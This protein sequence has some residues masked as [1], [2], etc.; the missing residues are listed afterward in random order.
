MK[1]ITSAVALAALLTL[2]GCSGGFAAP[3]L[4]HSGNAE[5]STESTTESEAPETSADPT[6]PADTAPVPTSSSEAPP[7]PVAPMPPI[8]GSG[9]DVVP[10][11]AT[12]FNAIKFTNEG[13]S[14]FVVKTDDGQLLVNEIG[15]YTGTVVVNLRDNEHATMLAITSSGNWTVTVIPPAAIPLKSG[16][17]AGSG[18]DVF[19]YEQ[20]M[21]PVTLS[22]PTCTSN[23][24]LH[25]MSLSS[26]NIDLLV[27]EI[28]A[29]TGTV[30]YGGP[31]LMM[32]TANAEWSIT[33]T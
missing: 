23:V 31:S 30:L 22:C 28:G 8:S 18:D 21:G 5:S 25:A 2:A 17:I 27:N 32:V 13:S 1:R 14:N 4:T 15:S 16:P 9:D 33:P 3:Q 19:V 12:G 24:V 10:M 6:T 29:Y 11:G 26:C 20:P 7:L